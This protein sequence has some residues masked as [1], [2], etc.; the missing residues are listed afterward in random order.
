MGSSGVYSQMLREA[1]VRF[2]TI[3]SFTAV[4][5]LAGCA[6]SA[7]HHFGQFDDLSPKVTPTQGER[8]PNHL[9]VQLARP[10]NVAV[11]LVV[12]GRPTMLLYPADSAQNGYVEA[13]IHVISTTCAS[14]ALS[15]SSRR[16]RR[17]QQPNGTRPTNQNRGSRGPLG[18]EV[19]MTCGSAL[20]GYLLMYASQQPLP[21]ASLVSGVAGLTVPIEDNDALNTVTKLVRERTHTSGPWAAY[22]TDFPP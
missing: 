19:P 14:I 13:G 7:P 4:A 22:A 5:L 12:P 10:A 3:G 2:A 18:P 21:Y 9:T 11:F 15:D 1:F 16:M 17:P 8:S 20:R 6:S